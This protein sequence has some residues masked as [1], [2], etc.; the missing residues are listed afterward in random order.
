MAPARGGRRGVGLFT[1]YLGAALL[2][3]M[4]LANAAV[5]AGGVMA[6]GENSFGALGDG[7][8]GGF[9]DVP[10]ATEL[11]LAPGVTVASVAA[12]KGF[13]LALLSNGTVLAWGE[14]NVGQLGNGTTTTGSTDV[15]VEVSGLSEVA[16]IAAG[17]A[18]SLAVLRNGTAKA[19]GAGEEGQIG[20]GAKVAAND[21]P[22]TVSG[23]SGVVAV[24]AG[25]GAGGED[26][27][28][29]LSDG[30]VKAW[31]SNLDA[32]LGDGS[33][34]GP[35]TCDGYPCSTTPVAVNGLSAATAIAAG[36]ANGIALLSNGTVKAWGANVFGE[37]G[38]GSAV[39][40][41]TCEGEP[42]SAIPVSV[43][44]LAEATAIAGGGS[45]NLALLNDETVMAWGDNY[46]GQLGDGTKAGPETCDGKPCSTVPVPVSG[47]TGVTAVS[48]GWV[49]SL[50]L[51]SDGSVMAWGEGPDGQLGN[52]TAG[53]SDIPVEA[54]GLSG[55][56]AISAGFMHS[57]AVV[58]AA[59]PAPIVKKLSP[60][61]GPAAGGTV[62]TITG[63]GF[64]GVTAV[65]FGS[66]R[67]K[68]F[69]VNSSTSITAES[70]AA[71]PGT[72]NLTVTTPNG[73]SAITAKDHFKVKKPKKTK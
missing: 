64:T 6:W 56:V 54:S 73:R 38:D 49:H 65:K 14:D 51:L 67:A 45:H 50:A 63:T 23:L 26:S 8:S 34:S 52:G 24:A 41:E 20:N 48:A 57:L 43:S 22:L 15:P 13:S 7:A 17:G 21:L 71:S 42:C 36:S 33:T 58:V 62:V 55:G 35:E 44:G 28:A 30:T 32:M 9:S 10:V 1:L 46:N 27:L 72:V 61:K 70:P 11:S 5:A 40:P 16:A 12:G 66:T 37:L 4:A 31:G 60:K 53:E 19:W 39:G 2:A 18:H 29:L 47:L 3:N 69:T 68:H 25:G 59:G